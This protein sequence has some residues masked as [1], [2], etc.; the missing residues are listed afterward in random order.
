VAV[1]GL[2]LVANLAA[3]MLSIRACRVIGVDL[4]AERRGLAERCGIEI[5]VGNSG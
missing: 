1:F 3:Q 2:G 5:T 4:M